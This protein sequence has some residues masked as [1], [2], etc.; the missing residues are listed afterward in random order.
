RRSDDRNGNRRSTEAASS[1]R[2]QSHTNIVLHL[3]APCTGVLPIGTSCVIR[4]VRTA[5]G[6]GPPERNSRAA[7]GSAA[8]GAESTACRQRSTTLTTEFRDHKA[9]PW[10]GVY[11]ACYPPRMERPS[12]PPPH[13][14][15][16]AYAGAE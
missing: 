4:Q 16:E 11:R 7:N 6:A 3:P 15:T 1:S 9:S 8:C 14:S 5:V 12:D 10:A 2:R 13:E